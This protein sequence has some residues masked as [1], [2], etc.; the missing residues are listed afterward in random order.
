MVDNLV[1]RARYIYHLLILT[2]L[3]SLA[4]R[5]DKLFRF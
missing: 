4:F 1:N 5:H 2:P 3:L